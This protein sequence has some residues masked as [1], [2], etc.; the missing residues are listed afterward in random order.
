MTLRKEEDTLIS[1]RKLWVALCGELALEEAL[2]L[3]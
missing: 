2:D 1:R 3:S